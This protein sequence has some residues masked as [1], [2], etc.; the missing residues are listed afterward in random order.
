MPKR[1]SSTTPLPRGWKDHIKS[2]V[3]QV[4]SLANYAIA[5]ARGRALNSKNA[6]ARRDAEIDRLRQEVALLREAMRIKDARWSRV[7]AQRRPHYTSTER[8]A[9][10]E[11]RAARGWTAQQSAD[12]FQVSAATIASW[13]SR[14]DEQGQ[15]PSSRNI[16]LK[17]VRELLRISP[18]QYL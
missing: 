17:I 11:V 6:K 1:K 8:M 3:L 15:F 14:I 7:P 4:I 18:R 9:I 12:A 16:G 5:Q 13:M 10:L 2:A